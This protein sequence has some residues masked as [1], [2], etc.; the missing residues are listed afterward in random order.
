LVPYTVYTNISY[1]AREPRVGNGAH[2]DWREAEAV[3]VE[4]KL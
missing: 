1:H 3:G 2:A 4:V